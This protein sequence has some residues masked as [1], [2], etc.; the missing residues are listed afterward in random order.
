ML[1][2]KSPIGSPFKSALSGVSAPKHYEVL[3][4]SLLL[5]TDIEVCSIPRPSRRWPKISYPSWRGSKKT[6]T[7]GDPDET[8]RGEALARCAHLSVTISNILNGCC[9]TFEI[10]GE[11]SRTL[12]TKGAITR[13]VNKGAAF[14]V[15]AGLVERLRQAIVSYQASEGCPSVSSPVNEE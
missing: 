2:N 12:L 11:I 6:T 14:G 13:F 4:D 15:V 7:D 8:E 3:I 10:F 5:A 9:S 1:R